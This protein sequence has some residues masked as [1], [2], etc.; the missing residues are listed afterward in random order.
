MGNTGFVVAATT[1]NATDSSYTYILKDR[2]FTNMTVATAGG[3]SG[4]GATTPFYLGEDDAPNSK[5]LVAASVRMQVVPVVSA[6]STTLII[7]GNDTGATTS[8]TITNNVTNASL[9]TFGSAGS[10]L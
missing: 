4:T 6:G 7:V 5:T 9:A 3:G 1:T 8:I 2:T 10:G